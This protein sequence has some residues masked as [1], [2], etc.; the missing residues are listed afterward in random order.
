MK[1]KNAHGLERVLKAGADPNITDFHKRTSLHLAINKTRPEDMF[2]VESVLLRNGADVNAA[3]D[4]G[5]TPLHYT[6]LT[7]EGQLQPEDH[8]DSV[9]C[10]ASLCDVKEIDLNVRGN[11]IVCGLD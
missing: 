9:E 6:F 2:E 4:M 8:R 3:D 11:N 5:R 1:L 7:Y 10:V